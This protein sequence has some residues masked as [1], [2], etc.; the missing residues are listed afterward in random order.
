MYQFVK[1]VPQ[2]IIYDFE[3]LNKILSKFRRTFIY[4]GFYGRYQ[5]PATNVHFSASARKK[6]IAE[7]C[8]SMKNAFVKIIGQ[9]TPLDDGTAYVTITENHHI[10]Y[11]YWMTF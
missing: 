5:N 11:A 1:K 7:Q 2:E 4:F 10:Y 8:E 3:K 6:E 9:Q